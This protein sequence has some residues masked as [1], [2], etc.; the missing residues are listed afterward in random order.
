MEDRERIVAAVDAGTET[1]PPPGCLARSRL[2][3]V[4]AFI[5]E[6]LTRGRIS[7]HALANAAQMPPSRFGRA[8]KAATG[9]SPRR[10]II[11]ARIR[12]TMRSMLERGDNLAALAAEAGFA[13][14]SHLAR[15][16]KRI[17]GESPSAW[18]RRHARVR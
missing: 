8:F 3:R 15:H 12:Y 10:A 6:N 11:E 16:F 18:R 2:R 1:A 9:V 14:Q 5:D 4:E 13:D 17:A 7:I